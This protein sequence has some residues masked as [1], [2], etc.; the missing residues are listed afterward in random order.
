MWA[1]WDG[2]MWPSGARTCAGSPARRMRLPAQHLAGARRCPTASAGAGQGDRP[3]DAVDQG[4]EDA[5]RGV[6]QGFLGY[7]PDMSFRS[8]GSL[9]A[10]DGWRALVAVIAGTLAGAV[11]CASPAN[12]LAAAGGL[13][14][15]FGS[16]GQ[17][18]FPLSLRGAQQNGRPTT[19]MF[20]AAGDIE[21]TGTASPPHGGEWRAFAARV[22]EDGTLDPSFGTGGSVVTS[23]PPSDE[24]SGVLPDH[25]VEA[26]VLEGDG[27]LVLAGPRTQGR[28]TPGGVFDSSFEAGNSPLNSFALA[29]LSGGDALAAGETPTEGN[30]PRYATLERLQ[31]DGAP[32]PSF[33]REGLV[34]L[35]TRAGPQVRE[36]ARSILALE[37]GDILIAGVGV[38]YGEGVKEETYDWLARVTPGGSLDPSFGQDGKQY[39][40]A[41]TP[42]QGERGVTLA[43]EPDG[44]I[45]LA[46]EEPT[47][48]GHWQAAAWG[49]L[50]DGS[51]D[52]S[53]GTGGATGIA[54][55]DAEATSQATTIAADSNGNLY[56]AVDQE[57]QNQPYHPGS[58][59]TRLTPSGQPDSAYGTGG[60]VSFAPATIDSLAVD[61]EG[62][63]NLA[64]VR[65]EEVFL[66]RLLG[67]AAPTTTTTTTT[68]PAV[69][70]PSNAPPG[71]TATHPRSERVSCSR[72]PRTVGHRRVE[73]C[74]LTLSYLPGRW[75]SVLVRIRRGH[76]L[77]AQRLLKPPRTSVTLRFQLPASNRKTNWT[78][79]LINGKRHVTIT[80]TVAP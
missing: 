45:V 37:D 75:K 16:G 39:V 80:R 25:S 58:F 5:S 76:R 68:T 32:D 69:G 51:P 35:P 74:T 78:V 63:L 43:R 6:E 17:V 36:S 71:G 7:L 57:S 59:V 15:S 9:D 50:S 62:R 34:Q 30:G 49:F 14:P 55:L 52:P 46:G 29:Y 20:T 47:G 38:I 28:L 65:G 2:H 33:G 22:R 27:A 11:V 48:A 44:V 24:G 23:L 21:V 8:L 18:S 66:A 13:D 72:A 61:S 19:L 31:P 67:G 12:A 79:T 26:G 40:P 56:I 73:L 60:T 10:S 70:N 41:L 53:F 54:P 42:Y 64:G 4:F 77:I 1:C 3:A